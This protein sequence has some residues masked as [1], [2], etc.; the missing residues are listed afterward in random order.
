MRRL[1]RF[2]VLATAAWLVGCRGATVVRWQADQT[3]TYQYTVTREKLLV[4]GAFTE[5]DT[6]TMRIAFLGGGATRVELDGG[7][8][9]FTLRPNGEIVPPEAEVPLIA[10][11]LCLAPHPGGSAVKIGSSWATLQPAD[12]QIRDD[13]IEL[14]LR[15]QVKLVSQTRA[16]GDTIVRLDIQGERR[17]VDNPLIRAALGLPSS[18]PGRVRVQDALG[19]LARWNGYLTGTVDWNVTRGVPEAA[20]LIL[21]PAPATGVPLSGVAAAR[22]RNHLMIARVR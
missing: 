12:S 18:D 3:Q 22:S 2:Q 15:Q 4:A 19:R 6:M 1:G 11:L 14:Q 9:S 5:R 8:S 16:G 7:V 20:D 10:R 17:L 13:R 21:V